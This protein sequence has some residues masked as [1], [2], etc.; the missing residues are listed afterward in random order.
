MFLHI[1]CYSVKLSWENAVE[2]H[3][4]VSDSSWKMRNA[5]QKCTAY[6][7]EIY[8]G[9]CGKFSW[10]YIALNNGSEPRRS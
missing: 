2:E 1:F 7:L 4:L 10:M 6:I 3:S 8:K 9:H 5:T